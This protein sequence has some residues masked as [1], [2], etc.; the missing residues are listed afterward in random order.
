M[1]NPC[2]T[3]LGI[4]RFGLGLLWTEHERERSSSKKVAIYRP[5]LC[6]HKSACRKCGLKLPVFAPGNVP[7]W[8]PTTPLI[9]K[10]DQRRTS[11]K[12][13]TS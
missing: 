6:S 5:L 4:S 11:A 7:L 12:V 13:T 9:H 10:S 2:S 1:N 8:T 3:V